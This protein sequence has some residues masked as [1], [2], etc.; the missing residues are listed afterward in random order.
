MNFLIIF[1]CIF[2]TAVVL[3][4]LGKVTELARSIRGEEDA[5]E[6]MNTRQGFLGMVFLIVFMVLL[7]NN[8]IFAI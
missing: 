6:D 8:K 3:V 1:L 7:K 2:L 5:Q 4:Q